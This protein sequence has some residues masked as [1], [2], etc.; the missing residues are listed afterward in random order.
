M[1]ETNITVKRFMELNP[2]VKTK[3][4]AKRLLHA[5]RTEPSVSLEELIADRETVN[6]GG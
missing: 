5:I 4:H 6:R 2:S 3:E 1:I